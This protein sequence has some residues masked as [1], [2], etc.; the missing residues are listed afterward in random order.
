MI[1]LHNN[2]A[3]QSHAHEKQQQNV[4]ENISAQGKIIKTAEWMFLEPSTHTLSIS[5]IT[6]GKHT[7][8][9]TQDIS[10]R[11]SEQKACGQ[12]DSHA[13]NHSFWRLTTH[14]IWPC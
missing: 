14:D 8:I 7:H 1:S 2:S 10:S 4:N 13:G 12:D 11:V 6:Q 3:Q 5:A 9:H